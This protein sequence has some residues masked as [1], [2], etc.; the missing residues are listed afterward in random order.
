M[1]GKKLTWYQIY[2]YICIYLNTYSSTEYNMC[3]YIYIYM[4]VY[5]C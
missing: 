4:C 2:I 1:C 3:I 5:V